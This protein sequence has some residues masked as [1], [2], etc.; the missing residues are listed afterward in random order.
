[1]DLILWRHAEA[2]EGSDDLHRAL[3]RKG[4]QQ[5]RSMAAWLSQRLPDDYVV[6]ASEAK[7]SKQTAAF[8]SKGYQVDA[9]L[10]PG[11]ALE[12]VLAVIDQYHEVDT[13]VLV[14]HQPYL[15]RLAA[16]L[17]SGD[18]Q[19]WNIKKGAIW[20][21]GLRHQTGGDPVRLKA[22]IT[23]GMLDD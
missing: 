6:L 16:R 1:M 13:V 18:P 20:W 19:Y 2:E 9:G 11:A 15:G 12:D 14:G 22:M 4:Q 5:G 17:M 23:P 3:T 21:L 10:N 7:R 8:L